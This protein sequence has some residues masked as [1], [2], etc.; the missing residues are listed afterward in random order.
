VN[1]AHPCGPS[2]K[3]AA[4]H[5]DVSVFTQE[6]RCGPSSEAAGHACVPSIKARRRKKSSVIETLKLARSWQDMIDKGEVKNASQIAADKNLT[7]ARVSQIMAF[8]R[9]AP[10]ILGYLED[11]D[12]DTDSQHLTERKIR[13]IAN[14]KDQAKQIATFEELVG[15]KLVAGYDEMGNITDVRL[16][17]VNE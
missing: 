16:S 13:C 6:F 4:C 1:G 9:L 10:P 8:L 12:R 2:L 5:S 11:V 14:I 17:A 3:N 7:R 15:M